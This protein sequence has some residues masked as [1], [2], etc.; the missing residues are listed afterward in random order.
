MQAVK[1]GVASHARTSPGRR[2]G[3]NAA[4]GVRDEHFRLSTFVRH[5]STSDAFYGNEHASIKEQFAGKRG[6]QME[7]PP[8]ERKLVAILAAD[9]AGYSRLME[10]DEEGT[11][12]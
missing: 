12:A 3:P 4:G 7:A 5:L 11:L 6:N 10:S 8:L 1:Q 2:G 9:V